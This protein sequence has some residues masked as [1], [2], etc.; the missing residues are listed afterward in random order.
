MELISISFVAGDFVRIGLSV[1]VVRID[2]SMI[3][4]CF[5][6]FFILIDFF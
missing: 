5:L 1:V 4:N 6:E 2:D 3:R